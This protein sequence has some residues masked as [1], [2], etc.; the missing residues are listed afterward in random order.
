[1][2]LLS[3]QEE[4]KLVAAIGAAERLTS[5]EIRIHLEKHTDKDTFERALEVFQELEMHQTEQ[6]NGVLFYLAYEDHRFTIL[7][8]EGIHAKVGADF[9]N[10]IKEE[11]QTRFRSG[12]FFEGLEYGV[13]AAGHALQEHFP[14]QRGDVNELSDEIS[15]S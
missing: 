4:K 13:L 10:E 14:Y 15:K 11:I 9:W 12:K 1:M 7:G 3:K 8:D 6:R 2:A 5:G